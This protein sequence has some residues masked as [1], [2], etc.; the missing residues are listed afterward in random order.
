[1]ASEEYQRTAR[2]AQS[3][4]LAQSSLVEAHLLHRPARDP[5]LAGGLP[6]YVDAAGRWC[7]SPFH[8]GDGLRLS[9]LPDLDASPFVGT[10]WAGEGRAAIGPAS[11][12]LLAALIASGGPRPL[13]DLAAGR[14]PDR[15]LVRRRYPM[16]DLRAAHALMLGL[17]Q[18]GLVERRAIRLDELG[19]L[20]WIWQAFTPNAMPSANPYPALSALTYETLAD[21]LDLELKRDQA[22]LDGTVDI[23]VGGPCSEHQRDDQ[24]YEELPLL[25]IG[26]GAMLT[27][28]VVL[29]QLTVMGAEMRRPWVDALGEHFFVWLDSWLKTEPV[30]PDPSVLRDLG[31]ELLYRAPWFGP[32]LRWT[33]ASLMRRRA[34]G[35]MLKGLLFAGLWS[36]DLV[37]R[38]AAGALS[39]TI[40]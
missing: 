14:L 16:P 17:E 19:R 15:P 13:A 29:Y 11:S 35:G 6:G 24:L 3:L 22:N 30:V 33:A 28:G 39:Y 20:R 37:A 1:M 26:D 18:R 40:A 32:S 38:A 31:M 9:E 36:D 7:L 12:A 4:M 2:Q 25:D 8:D 10:V 5:V 27:P 21:L 23:I 34:P